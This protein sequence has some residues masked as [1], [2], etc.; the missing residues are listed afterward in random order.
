MFQRAF[1]RNIVFAQYSGVIYIPSRLSCFL[2]SASRRSF[3][4]KREIFATSQANF[5]LNFVEPV[6]LPLFERMRRD[7]K[8]LNSDII[9]ARVFIRNQITRIYSC[10]HLRTVYQNLIVRLFGSFK[11]TKK[12][13][14]TSYRFLIYW[15]KASVGWKVRGLRAIEPIFSTR[16]GKEIRKIAIEFEEDYRNLLEMQKLASYN[17]HFATYFFLNIL[18]HSL[19]LQ[20][21]TWETMNSAASFSRRLLHLVKWLRWFWRGD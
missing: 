13:S 10:M 15:K 11:S 3:S 2:V 21:L 19:F 8:R 12:N 4:S 14:F 18:F 16:I 17:F 7:K 5:I 20:P 1:I 9:E 6:R